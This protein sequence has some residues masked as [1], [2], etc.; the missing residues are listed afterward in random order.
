MFFGNFGRHLVWARFHDIVA[1]LGFLV[2]RVDENDFVRRYAR[3]TNS[4]RHVDLWTLL[5][6]MHELWLRFV[7]SIFF[8]TSW[9]ALANVYRRINVVFGRVAIPNVQTLVLVRIYAFLHTICWLASQRLYFTG[10]YNVFIGMAL[11]GRRVP[12]RG[13]RIPGP[14]IN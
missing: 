3:I 6:R 12:C 9:H 14:S 11:V 7:R 8:L 10:S 13:V 4:H 5:Y 2:F 1:R